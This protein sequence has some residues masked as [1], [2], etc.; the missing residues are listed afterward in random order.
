MKMNKMKQNDIM[1]AI[2]KLR[3]HYVTIIDLF[4]RKE[5]AKKIPSGYPLG[6]WVVIFLI[7]S[8]V[9]TEQISMIVIHDIKTDKPI[10]AP[11]QI[12]ILY[13]HF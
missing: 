1:K 13:S 4:G 6:I 8:F 2:D 12:S 5:R 9:I 10:V 7:L 11:H 3:F